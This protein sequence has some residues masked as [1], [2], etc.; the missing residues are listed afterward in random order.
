MHFY[1]NH[2]IYIDKVI[3]HNE[4]PHSVVT[5]LQILH[6]FFLL[7]F[8]NFLLHATHALLLILTLE[9]PNN[10]VIHC[11]NC[12]INHNC[13]NYNKGYFYM[14]SKDNMIFN[15]HFY[16]LLPNNQEI[17]ICIF[18]I[19]FHIQINNFTYGWLIYLSQLTNYIYNID[20]VVTQSQIFFSIL[21]NFK[22][23]LMDSLINFF[24]NF[25]NFLFLDR[26]F[27]VFL[28]QNN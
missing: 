11:C 10:L 9:H 12:I 16:D 14:N 4:T 19:Q 8:L 22:Y 5:I 15:I 23:F 1:N 26:F 7:I 28:H 20:L 3:N 21:I 25:V 13:L 24:Q 27:E 6:F 18:R 2:M 17:L